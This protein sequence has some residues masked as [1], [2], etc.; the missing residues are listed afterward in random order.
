MLE[1]ISHTYEDSPVIIM[2]IKKPIKKIV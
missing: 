2:I 1:I